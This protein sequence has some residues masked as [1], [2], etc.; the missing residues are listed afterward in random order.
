MENTRHEGSLKSGV[1]CLFT[2][3]N[4]DFQSAYKEEPLIQDACVQDGAVGVSTTQS[5]I[6]LILKSP[7]SS[8]CR[9]S[10]PKNSAPI[11]GDHG[12]PRPTPA[13]WQ[14]YRLVRTE[15]TVLLVRNL[16]LLMR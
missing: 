7:V 4:C 6:N 16:M 2:D 15:T 5:S 12:H 8:I 9:S 1:L 3:R 10:T 11:N 14:K 13:R